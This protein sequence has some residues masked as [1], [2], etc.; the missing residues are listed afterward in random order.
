MMSLPPL[1]ADLGIYIASLFQIPTEN[2]QRSTDLP[3]EKRG[4]GGAIPQKVASPQHKT[5]K[6]SSTMVTPPYAPSQKVQHPLAKIDHPSHAPTLNTT[7]LPKLLIHPSTLTPP[8]VNLKSKPTK[9]T[10]V[11][12]GPLSAETSQLLE[13]VYPGVG[14]QHI[15][16]HSVLPEV[17]TQRIVSDHFSGLEVAGPPRTPSPAL[18][19]S[20]TTSC[21]SSPS[22]VGFLTSREYLQPAKNVH[23]HE[24]FSIINHHA[25]LVHPCRIQ[26]WHDDKFCLDVIDRNQDD[27]VIA[28]VVL[29]HKFRM[30]PGVKSRRYVKEDGAVTQL[31][32]CSWDFP[33]EYEFALLVEPDTLN[34]VPAR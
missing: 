23:V 11:T 12:P 8:P 18:S 1:N 20:H 2:H 31:F 19:L 3:K 33:P 17:V 5:P 24:G 22:P 28:Q 32:P 30:F 6:I 21:P 25:C 14:P 7:D 15:R 4:H 27:D 9:T 29:N 10:S 13:A 26:I 16:D 34:E